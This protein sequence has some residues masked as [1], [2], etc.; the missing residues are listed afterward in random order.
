MGNHDTV[1]ARTMR[2]VTLV[3]G[4]VDIGGL[5]VCMSPETQEAISVFPQ[6]WMQHALVP[7]KEEVD[8]HVKAQVE[9]DGISEEEAQRRFLRL[10]P[11][12]ANLDL[13][14]R[15]DLIYF[16]KPYGNL[17]KTLDRLQEISGHRPQQSALAHYLMQKHGK[18][19]ILMGAGHYHGG[20]LGRED[21][22]LKTVACPSI[23]YVLKINAHTKKLVDL[24]RWEWKPK[25]GE[26]FDPVHYEAFMV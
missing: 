14:R 2:N 5:S 19:I 18:Q 15:P 3:N 21:G 6:A 26:R 25:K 24:E 1:H 20:W 11:Q 17:G 7:F 13:E 16:H 4:F 22:I 23:A 12:F 8:A 9:Q 10:S